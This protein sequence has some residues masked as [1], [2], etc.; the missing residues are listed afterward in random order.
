METLIDLLKMLVK[1]VLLLIG[2]LLVLGGGLCAVTGV[3]NVTRGGIV[4][5]GIAGVVALIGWGVIQLAKA[6][7]GDSREVT[8]VTSEESNRL[9]RLVLALIVVVL[10]TAFSLSV[11]KA[12]LR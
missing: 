12:L 1:G 10:G 2:G 4:I 8:S 11:L 3:A 7:G 6:I 9:G 5:A